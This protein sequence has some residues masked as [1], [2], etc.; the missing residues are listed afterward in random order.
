[1]SYKLKS[2]WLSSAKYPLK[3]PYAMR[4]AGI[5]VHNTAGDASATEETETAPSTPQSAPSA[6]RWDLTSSGKTAR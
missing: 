2:R 5:V 6:K 4:P 3:S 1:M